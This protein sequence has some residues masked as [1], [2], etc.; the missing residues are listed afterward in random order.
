MKAFVSLFLAAAVVAA[1]LAHS[2]Q[3]GANAAAIEA[4]RRW[5]AASDAGDGGATWDQAAPSF[6]TAI[7]KADWAAAL[8]R[9]RQPFGAVKDRKVAKAEATRSLPGAPDGEYVVI[10]YDTNFEGKAHATETVIP[11]RGA[12]GVW[13]VSG[14]FVR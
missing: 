10:E 6:Q 1:P 12:D 2:Q 4:A 9:A 5:M 7:A 8:S 11:V 3:T 13:R 14:Y